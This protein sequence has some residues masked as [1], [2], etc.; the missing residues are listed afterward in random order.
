MSS[1]IIE[2]LKDDSKYYGDF[3]KQY[4]S[5]SDIYSL[6]KNPRNFRNNEKS[7]PLIMGGYFHTAM[8][9]P[10]KKET[11]SIMDVSTRSTKAFKEYISDNDLHPYDVLLTKEVET[12]STWV[13]SMKSNFEM[14][15]DI[16]SEGNI[17]EQPAVANIF[18][19]KWKGKADIITADKIIDIKTTGNI[20]KFKWSAND[21]NYDSQAYIYEQLFGK[22]V[23]F[24]I[25]DKT[26]LKLKISKPSTET[27]LRGRDKVLK[28]IEVYKKFFAEDSAEDITQYIEREEF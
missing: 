19:M 12:I 9:E 25:I 6:L 23:E 2:D 3:G 10:E 4:L 26:T 15:T 14:Y 21:Y 28:A 17:Y 16:Y 7:L 27:L 1:N 8:L 20:D 24:Y 13:E 22:P 11:Y 18:G 5:N